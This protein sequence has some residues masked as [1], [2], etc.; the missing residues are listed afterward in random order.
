MLF[1]VFDFSSAVR[2]YNDVCKKNLDSSNSFGLSCFD[3]DLIDDM[4]SASLGI[5]PFVSNYSGD[6]FELKESELQEISKHLEVAIKYYELS[7]LEISDANKKIPSQIIK[8]F[9]D[10]MID[11][12]LDIRRTRDMLCDAMLAKLKK[13]TSPGFFNFAHNYVWARGAESH[14]NLLKNMGWIVKNPGVKLI[15]RSEKY[16]L[17]PKQFFSDGLIPDSVWLKFLFKGR[18]FRLSLFQ[19][20]MWLFAKLYK[21]T[22]DK[23]AYGDLKSDEIILS[24]KSSDQVMAEIQSIDSL[25]ESWSPKGLWKYLCRNLK[26]FCESWSDFSKINRKLVN[27]NKLGL[28]G[29]YCNLVRS[30]SRNSDTLEKE[31]PKGELSYII[32]SIDAMMESCDV[33]LKKQLKVHR[34][35]LKKLR[36]GDV[37]VVKKTQKESDAHS[38][39]KVLQGLS[40]M[41]LSDKH[42]SKIKDSIQLAAVDIEKTKTQS[43]RK[44]LECILKVLFLDYLKYCLLALAK[45]EFDP[46]QEKIKSVE[47][48][49]QKFASPDVVRRLCSL[50]SVRS[51]KNTD[52]IYQAMCESYVA[53][54]A[55]DSDSKKKNVE[56]LNSVIADFEVCGKFNLSCAS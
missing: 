30:K 37:Q 19:D 51:Q 53:S 55:I 1:K 24:L 12:D 47:Y 11:L 27:G 45:K 25:C 40:L 46:T 33:S 15:C 17:V 49:L 50:T 23:V 5:A 43:S 39:L 18:N 32:K 20:K 36:D 48:L 7:V 13:K 56:A 6:F 26:K 35:V 8:A 54:Y 3:G 9:S 10:N 14:Q 31:I 16:F 38:V 52:A 42:L 41:E 4:R 34:G 2:S 28:I 29:A 21:I 44:Q 22:G